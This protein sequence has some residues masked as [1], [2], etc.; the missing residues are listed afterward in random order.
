MPLLTDDERRALQGTLGAEGF[1]TYRQLILV[2][3][4][5][6][7]HTLLHAVLSN[8]LPKKDLARARRVSKICESIAL[9]NVTELKDTPLFD[10]LCQF[11]DQALAINLSAK[12]T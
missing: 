6:T 11:V 10:E 4:F 3:K 5:D 2:G 1:D 9:G 12:I 7:L 8:E